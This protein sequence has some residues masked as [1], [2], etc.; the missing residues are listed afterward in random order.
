MHESDI[1]GY[2]GT[3][4][5]LL[6]KAKVSIGDLI[7]INKK[8]E[9]YEGILLPRSEYSDVKH[10]LIKMK[11]G[12]NIGVAIDQYTKV[13]LIEKG[14]KP[15]YE[16]SFSEPVNKK[17]EKVTIISTGGTIASRVDYRTGAVEPALSAKDLYAAVPELSKIA[18]IETRILYKEFS[19]N[20]EPK[21]WTGMANAIKDEIKKGVEG[22][23]IGHGTDT[24]AY[25]S[26][27]LSFALQ[28][29]PIPVVLVGS[30]RSSDRPSSD[31]ASNLIS[32]ITVAKSAPF[33]E[34]VIA[35][36]ETK[37]DEFISVHRGTRVRKCHT[38]G[39]DAF[40]TINSP[41]F[42]RFDVDKKNLTINEDN[43]LKREPS[44]KIQFNPNFN[45]K[46]MLLKFYP[47]IDPKIIDWAIKKEYLGIIIEGTGLGHVGAYTHEAIKKA[48]DNGLLIGMASQ[49]I[50]GRVNMNVYY[51]GRDL[52][53]LG[54]FPL[55]DMLPETALVKM[56]WA[57]G[58]TKNKDKVKE[59]MLKNIAWE[60][61]QQPIGSS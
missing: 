25:S 8:N 55:D 31:A 45:D 7:Q 9:T 28:N 2:H 18:S 38:S 21:H 23:V 58:Q 47:G 53:A 15:K 6:T 26:A 12:Y 10:I 5:E 52:S 1:E 49:C 34:I 54:V 17:L 33:A 50:W 13:S 3:V 20:L 11:S 61:S 30:Q 51:T 37:A 44:N 27:A 36:H 24:M 60:F 39:R 16:Y 41:V 29:L 57:F 46:A 4:F 43:Y 22:I 19:E 42:A 56:M 35:M 32:A 14:S 48:I 40:R 59:I